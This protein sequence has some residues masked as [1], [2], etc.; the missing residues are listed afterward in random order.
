MSEE[1]PTAEAMLERVRREAGAGA[2]GRLRIYLGMAP[3]V[4]KTYAML[5]EARR[6]KA[7]GTDVVVG[8][9]E[10]YGRPLTIEA[11]GDLEIVPRRKIPYQNVTLE[12][13][14]TAAVIARHPD[15]ALVDELAHTNAPGS[16][17]EKRWQDVQDLLDAGITVLST[18]NVQHLESL[19]DMVE[20]ITGVQ[21]R[22]RIP[23]RIID[24]AD[25][26]EIVD[27]T[28]HALRQRIRH[29]N[30]YPPDR[31]QQALDHFF[32][33]GNLN[34]LRELALRRMSTRVEHDLEDYMKEN[35]VAE[36]WPAAEKVL[37][38]VGADPQA[39]RLVRRGA[40]EAQR[41]NSELV[42]VFVEPPDWQR[43]D[44][45]AQGRVDDTLRLA[46]DLGAEVVRVA[47]KDVVPALAQV[48]RDMNAATLIVGHRHR[49]W[50]RERLRPPLAMRLLPLIGEIDLRVVHLD[51]RHPKGEETRE[52]AP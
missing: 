43:E 15:V 2:R 50:V 44:P 25:E 48:A 38:A 51:E 13:M 42:V 33:E 6:R 47:A 39:Q 5:G 26:I 30:V 3:G 45:K 11:L 27:V 20:T 10:T 52:L 12:E 37:V 23:D 4:G 32:R 21:V 1:R 14:D 40:R 36:V 35:E 46:R 24:E 17:H 8:F 49:G 34:A 41:A 7:R 28:P 22:E 18:V 29:G 9:V 19:A 16:A 31:S